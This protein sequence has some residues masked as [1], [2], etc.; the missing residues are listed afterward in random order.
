MLEKRIII[1]KWFHG[2]CDLCDELNGKDCYFGTLYQQHMN[3]R[4]ILSTPNFAVIPTIGQIAEG[5]VLILPFKHYTSIGSLPG[6]MILELE[7]LVDFVKETI[8]S[9]YGVEPIFFE[10]GTACEG[11]EN[12]GCGIYHMHLHAVPVKSGVNLQMSMALPLRRIDSF[13][14][15]QGIISKGRSYLLYI[16]QANNKFV[17]DSNERIPS[18]YMRKKLAEA[19]GSKDWD[20]RSYQREE[21]L[22]LT[23][24]KLSTAVAERIG[25]LNEKLLHC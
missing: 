16:D 3:N 6:E 9:S 21:R 10:H 14:E 22:I 1:E 24:N 12:G 7:L 15:L 19:L 17:N 13:A 5:H 20:W 8:I 11:K 2:K 23:Y 18:Q 4:I 25:F